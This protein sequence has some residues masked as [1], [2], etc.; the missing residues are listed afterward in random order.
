MK[1]HRGFTLIELLV[2]IAI[3]AVLIALLLPAV[4]QAREAARRMQCKNNLKQLGLAMHNY[5]STYRQ[6]PPSTMQVKGYYQGSL[7]EFWAWSAL[8]MMAPYLDQT[9][10]YN[11]MDLSQPLYVSGGSGSSGYAISPKN[12]VAAG[13]LV[14]MFLCPSDAGRPVSSDYEVNGLGPANYAV[15]I[16]T[17]ANLG[18]PFDTD[19]MFFAASRIGAGGVTDGLSNTVAMAEC[20]LG[21]GAEHYSGTVAVKDQKFAYA[22]TGGPVSDAGCAAASSWNETNRKGFLWAAGEIRTTAYNHYYGPNSTKWDCIGYDPNL[23]YASTGW[24]AARSMHVGTVNVLMGDGSGRSISENI[25]IVVWRNLSTR[26][27]GETLGEF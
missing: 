26:A 5:E 19:G 27:G 7:G 13:M 6:F 23:G 22:Y 15:C 4:Q 17:G 18:S 12:K 2:V 20:L 1:R 24:H 8:A 21:Q 16:G 10:L 11:S 14:P 9:N 25:D 3:I